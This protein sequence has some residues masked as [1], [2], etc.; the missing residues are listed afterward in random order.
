M[1]VTVLLIQHSGFL[2]ILRES[3]S[4]FVGHFVVSL[5]SLAGFH[6]SVQ[7]LRASSDVLEFLPSWSVE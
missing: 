1:V 3:H 7:W 4:E 2:D 6:H 5:S